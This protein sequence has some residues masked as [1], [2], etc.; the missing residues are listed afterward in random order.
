MILA[1]GGPGLGFAYLNLAVTSTR[2]AGKHHAF[3]RSTNSDRW[4]KDDIAEWQ[5]LKKQAWHA[6]GQS[7]IC[8]RPR[9]P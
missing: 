9:L 3:A 4:R 7:S 5:R 1:L 6:I 8:E 2:I